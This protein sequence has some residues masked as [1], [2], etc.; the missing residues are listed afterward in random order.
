[1]STNTIRWR[2][3]TFSGGGNNA[4]V[5]L[6]LHWRKSSFSGGNDACVEVGTHWRKS[7]YSGGNDECVEVAST[8]VAVRDSKNPAGP[9]L[10]A[11]LQGLLTAVKAGQLDR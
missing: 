4:C 2:K 3:T 10:R 8:L 6:G 11:D 7:S 1:M 9:I 5:E